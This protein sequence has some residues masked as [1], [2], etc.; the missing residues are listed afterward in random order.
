MHF[1]WHLGEYLPLAEMIAANSDS[2]PDVS[3]LGARVH[4]LARGDERLNE[5]LRPVYIDYLE[6]QP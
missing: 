4:E 2:T 1:F 3:H 5:A 6:H